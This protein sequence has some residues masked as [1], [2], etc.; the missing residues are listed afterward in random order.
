MEKN[1]LLRAVELSKI[2]I[3][4]NCGPF[5]AIIVRNG[6]IIAE[7]HNTVT[8]DNDPTA[9]A[10]VNAIRKAAQN[11]SNFDLSDCEIYTSTEPCPMCLSAIYW[12]RMKKVYYANTRQDAA[13]I[14][15]D[16]EY[17]YNELAKPIEQRELEMKKIEIPEAKEVFNL[18]MNKENKIEY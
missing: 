17:I 3:D 14:N 11:L 1:F 10:E 5:G 6:E 18:W 15:F 4:E 9:H 13:A 12:S 7:A 2:S 8:R 16:D